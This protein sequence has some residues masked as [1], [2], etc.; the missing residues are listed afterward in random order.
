MPFTSPTS[1]LIWAKV[2]RI[3]LKPTAAL[4]IFVSWM[5][6]SFSGVCAVVF[7]VLMVVVG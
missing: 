1:L 7:L 5:P 3:A 4:G 2:E 6:V